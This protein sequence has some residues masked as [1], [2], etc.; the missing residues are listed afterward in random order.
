MEF[1]RSIAGIP[2][3]LKR[4]KFLAQIAVTDFL[5]WVLWEEPR[6]I[7]RAYREYAKAVSEILSIAY[8]LRT[9]MSPWKGIA[10]D[11]PSVVQWDKFLQAFFINLVTRM[12]GAVIRLVTIV[13]ALVLQVLLLALFLVLFVGWFVFPLIALAV[14]AVIFIIV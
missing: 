8:L 13:V 2:S 3:L 6:N 4:P 12:I 11:M 9:L 14:L 5:P 7:L 1:L 10:E